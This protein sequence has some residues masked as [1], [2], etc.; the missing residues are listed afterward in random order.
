MKLYT[1]EHAPWERKNVYYQ[2]IQLGNEVKDQTVA[3]NN[4]IKAMVAAQLTAADS[5]VISQERIKEGIDQVAYGTELVGH[6]LYDLI[7]PRGRPVCMFT[8]TIK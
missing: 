4:Q 5:L 7:S 2:N 1:N 8:R 6:G 3:I